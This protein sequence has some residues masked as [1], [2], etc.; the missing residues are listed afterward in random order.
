MNTKLVPLSSQAIAIAM[1][2]LQVLLLLF[3]IKK[4]TEDILSPSLSLFLDLN[5]FLKCLCYQ[6]LNLSMK[7]A[8]T[9]VDAA[10]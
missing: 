7:K 2:L 8:P 6:L 4:D 3:L 1:A 9:F 10:I 5:I